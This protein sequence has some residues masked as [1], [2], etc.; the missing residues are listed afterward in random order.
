MLGTSNLVL[1]KE[2]PLNKSV[3]DVMKKSKVPDLSLESPTKINS[4]LKSDKVSIGSPRGEPSEGQNSQRASPDLL[5]AS[6][7]R[8]EM[9]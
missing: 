3:V 4:Y 5:N 9:I 8:V 2:N 7:I 1:R 6:P